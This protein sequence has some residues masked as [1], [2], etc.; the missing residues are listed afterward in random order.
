M[1]K[2]QTARWSGSDPDNDTLSY[3][4][5][6]SNDSGVTWKPVP[7]TVK[8]AAIPAAPAAPGS[9]DSQLPTGLDEVSKRLDQMPLSEVGK[10]EMLARFKS[11][12]DK[13]AGL[14]DNTPPPLEPTRD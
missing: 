12:M 6:Y 3:D 5:L 7:T 13:A 10:L 14:E 9:T 1:V 2:T 4:L 11:Q 8:E